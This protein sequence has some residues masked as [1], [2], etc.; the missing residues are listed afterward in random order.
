MRLVNLMKNVV[1]PLLFFLLLASIYHVAKATENKPH[2]PT[3]L[4]LEDS[5][6]QIKLIHKAN[7]KEVSLYIFHLTTGGGHFLLHRR[8]DGPNYRIIVFA[9]GSVH[10]EN[11]YSPTGLLGTRHVL[12]KKEYAAL[13]MQLRWIQS[14]GKTDAFSGCNDCN[15]HGFLAGITTFVDG[16][17]MDQTYRIDNIEPYAEFRRRIEPYVHSLK[18]RC[19]VTDPILTGNLIPKGKKFVPVKEVNICKSVFEFDQILPKSKE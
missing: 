1:C 5:E 2:V 11:R 16:K 4:R 13:Q 7:K 19:P 3:D 17:Y 12:R 15:G 6:G 14:L 10:F 18:Y 9:D 8:K